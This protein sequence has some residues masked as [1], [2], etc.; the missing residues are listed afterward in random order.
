MPQQWNSEVDESRTRKAGWNRAQRIYALK[1]VPCQGCQIKPAEHRHHVDGNTRDNR[2]SNIAL[3]CNSCHQ[4]AHAAPVPPCIIC[5]SS[6]PPGKW[7]R[8]GRCAACTSYL[9]AHGVERTEYLAADKTA[10]KRAAALL[11]HENRGR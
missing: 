7:P 9:R 10:L 8:K 2:P 1:G 11:G 5:G 3:L 6:F 4:R